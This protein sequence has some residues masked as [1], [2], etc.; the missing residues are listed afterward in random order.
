[1]SQRLFDPVALMNQNTEA[2]ATKRTPLPTGETTAQIV[3]MDIAEGTSGPKSK[4]PGTPWARLD[5][6]MEITDPEYLKQVGDGTRDKAIIFHGIMLD[7]KD[8][9]IATGA[10]R[11]V[12]LGR[13]REAAGV[14]GQ[15]L[16]AL[17]GQWVRLQIGHK[18]HFENPQD[19]QHEITAITALEQQ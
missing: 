13:L 1:M 19:I 14:N 11:N 18:P 3:K 12:V 6:Q 7:M 16:N 10:D 17:M 15:P 4:H 5:L 9:A 8:G 2:N